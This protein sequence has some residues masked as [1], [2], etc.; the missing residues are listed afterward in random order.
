MVLSR[1]EPE[2]V[3]GG[4]QAPV[5][6]GDETEVPGAFLA[7]AGVFSFLQQHLIAA[8]D[9]GNPDDQH[10][11]DGGKHQDGREA[12]DLQEG[13]LL[14]DNQAEEQ[15]NAGGDAQQD[16]GDQVTGMNG[17]EFLLPVLYHAADAVKGFHRLLFQVLIGSDP[18]A[19]GD[20]Q[21][22]SRQ[23]HQ[24]QDG[25]AEA[26]GSLRGPVPQAEF[27]NAAQQD[28][29]H[30]GKDAQQNAQGYAPGVFFLNFQEGVGFLHADGAGGIVRH[31]FPGKI[32]AR[33]RV[34]RLQVVLQ[35]VI[36]AD[37]EQL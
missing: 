29:R 31:R 15:G 14:A 34:R 30:R 18:K 3:A 19:G 13:I 22:H 7:V 1:E 36:G 21:A 12:D 23:D 35:Q 10:D 17:L 11:A 6:A 9:D 5:G 16:A 33:C 26:R 8:L 4:D 27:M 32:R 20:E 37:A 25:Q 28:Q 24:D 2:Q